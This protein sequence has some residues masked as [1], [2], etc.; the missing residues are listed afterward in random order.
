MLPA[1]LHF[2]LLSAAAGSVDPWY[3]GPGTN[4]NDRSSPAIGIAEA[5][6]NRKLVYAATY[7]SMPCEPAAN[8]PEPC[9][10]T[11]H[12]IRPD[13]HAFFADVVSGQPQIAW[14]TRINGAYW[15]NDCDEVCWASGQCPSGSTC[16]RRWRQGSQGSPSV[17]DDGDALMGSDAGQLFGFHN[18][19][20]PHPNNNERWN[21]DA[22]AFVSMTP[23]LIPAGVG[24]LSTR[25]FIYWNE[26]GEIFRA[27]DNG[28][29]VTP[30]TS[31][32]DFNAFTQW[33]TAPAIDAA[34]RVFVAAPDGTVRGLTTIADGINR[35]WRYIEPIPPLPCGQA[36]GAHAP[37]AIDADGTL[38]C[39]FDGFVIALR[40]RLGDFN[41]D[42]LTNNFDVDPFVLAL[43][44]EYWWEH[45]DPGA[46][47][48]TG[49]GE[50]FQI[51]MLGVGDCNNDGIFDNFD[52]DCFVELLA[53]VPACPE[54]PEPSSASAPTNSNDSANSETNADEPSDEYVQARIAEVRAYFGMQ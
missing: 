47:S 4:F 13:F 30:L 17:F 2:L 6:S 43:L 3:L 22:G 26:D 41:G 48:D 28:T 34:G 24:G 54:C 32:T 36:R 25:S 20:T 15:D 10:E 53:G 49:F 8:Y 42:G 50:R 31:L 14:Q 51:N 29:S 39:V 9:E 23:G 7:L 33:D 11:Y 45:T 16:L 44:D 12:Q 52:I 1:S 46:P 19:G 38:I 35:D 18:G 37:V 40:P 21:L 5:K 27:K